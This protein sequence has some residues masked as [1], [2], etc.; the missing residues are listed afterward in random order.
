MEFRGW[1]LDNWGIKLLSLGFSLAL[2]FYVTSTG[3]TELTLSI[4]IELRN[5]P[6]GMTVVGDVPGKLEVRM[7][8]QER[9]LRD[10][11]IAKK[12]VAVLDLSRTREGENT[13]RISPDDIVRPA[14]SVVKHLSLSE[15]KVRLE[16]I[17]QK[18]L[19]LKPVLHG[20]PASGYRLAG[21]AVTPSRVILE[22]PASVMKTISSVETMPIDIR[23]ASQ[24]ITVEARIDYRGMPVKVMEKSIAVRVNIERT[25]K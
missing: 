10:G 21:T 2:W 8:G 18:S 11:S 16:R 23:K 20:S 4:P 24:S 12:V 6:A 9:V 17:V 14:G 13:I 3:K 1:I 7:Q 19:R 25:G 15:I 22:G 5:V